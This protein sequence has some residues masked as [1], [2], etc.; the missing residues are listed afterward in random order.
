MVAYRDPLSL[1]DP[2]GLDL[3]TLHCRG[4]IVFV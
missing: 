3:L 4:R 2:V 1:K